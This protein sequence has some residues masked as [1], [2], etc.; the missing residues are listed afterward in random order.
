VSACRA[1]VDPDL[2]EDR[3]EDA[4]GIGPGHL[5]R[6]LRPE[7][8]ESLSA[9][10]ADP[11]NE[12]VTL[13]AQG[14]RSSLTGG[15]VPY[16]GAVLDTSHWDFIDPPQRTGDTDTVRCGAGV[17]LDDLR[18]RL[19]E[20]GLDY[21]PV[22]TYPQAT[23]GGV[24]S[25]NAAGPATF[26]Y[27][28]TRGWVQALELLLADGRRLYL[29]RGDRSVRSGDEWVLE[30]ET[31]SGDLRVPHPGYVTPAFK[32]IS[33]GYGGFDPLDPVDLF[34]GSEGTLGIVTAATLRVVPKA[35]G[36]LALLMFVPDADAAISAAA[37]LREV[38]GGETASLRSTEFIDGAA[39]DVLREDA[40]PE[41]GRIKI[42]GDAGSVLSIEIEWNGPLESMDDPT[43]SR[44]L[45]PLV[46]LP[47]F[48]DTIVAMPG[49]E[50]GA[51]M[52]RSFRKAV[53]MAV[54]ERARRR[55]VGSPKEK[56]AA[57]PAVPPHRLSS[58]YAFC[59]ESFRSRGV[60]FAVWGHL[61]DGNL[62][63]NAMPR[64]PQE[65]LAAGEAIDALSA[66]AIRLGGTPLAEHGVGRQPGKQAWLRRLL[67]E[68]AIAGMRR[69]KR[70]LDPQAR[71]APGVLW[72]EES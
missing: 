9:W 19:A 44:Y 72:P 22:P 69:V 66:E 56:R 40:P 28:Q 43:L 33:A 52:I 60:P 12:A 36:I 49:D 37:T 53:P 50:A 7:T 68:D 45:A 23:V 39:L 30:G 6:L 71:L 26:K 57:D 42:P 54:N 4:S 13:L 29:Q 14:S 55:P 32:K 61:S 59:A 11:A 35:H 63:P 20:A 27:G 38:E 5:D 67:G 65:D 70:A 17:R 16:G 51:E 24:I 2:L 64:T 31:E 46:E 25:T 8:A 18:R 58:F 1:I 15:A 48:D 41:I 21:P 34:I 62:H 10:L 47:G 3:I